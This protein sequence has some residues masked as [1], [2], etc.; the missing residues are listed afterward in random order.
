M[1]PLTTSLE[2][3]YSPFHN[4]D[5]Y[6]NNDL[7]DDTNNTKA[8]NAC[9]EPYNSTR[10]THSN[11]PVDDRDINHSDIPIND[12]DEHQYDIPINNIDSRLIP[13]MTR[14]RKRTAVDPLVSLAPVFPSNLVALNLIRSCNYPNIGVDKL[15]AE[16][17][18]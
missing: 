16:K 8:D 14:L 9:V 11:S 6:S 13:P 3:H 7:V 2:Q 18:G 1:L 4:N 12:K 10:S 17:N 5:F 15:F